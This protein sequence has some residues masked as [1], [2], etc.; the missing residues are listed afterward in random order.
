MRRLRFRQLRRNAGT[1]GVLRLCFVGLVLAVV[2]VVMLIKLGDPTPLICLLVG[3][4]LPVLARRRLIADV[5]RSATVGRYLGFAIVGASMAFG[6][7]KERVLTV[8]PEALLVDATCLAA[9][10]YLGFF[11]VLYADPDVVRTDR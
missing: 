7:A 1:F 11:V 8:V 2:S 10:I 4:S 6:L 5:E 9:A 3:A